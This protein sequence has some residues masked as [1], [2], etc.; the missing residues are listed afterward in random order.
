MKERDNKKRMPKKEAKDGETQRLKRRIRRLEKENN[1][2]KSELRSYDQA[3][4]KMTKHIEHFTDDYSVEELIESARASK[5]PKKVEVKETCHSC[6]STNVFV[7]S[8]P[9]GRLISCQDCGKVKTY[10][11]KKDSKEEES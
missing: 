5:K 1:K 11:A 9:F 8:L 6:M 3:F 10:Y 7:G 4:K 2:L